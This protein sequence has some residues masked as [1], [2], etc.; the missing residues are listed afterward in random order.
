MTESLKA[1]PSF[2][3]FQSDILFSIQLPYIFIKC[4]SKPTPQ[5]TSSFHQCNKNNLFSCKFII[6]FAS[7][8]LRITKD[9]KNQTRQESTTKNNIATEMFIVYVIYAKFIG[10]IKSLSAEEKC[11][12]TVLFVQ[13]YVCKSYTVAQLAGITAETV[14]TLADV[15]AKDVDVAVGDH[16]TAVVYNDHLSFRPKTA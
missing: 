11:S 6:L 1:P 4:I 9:N 7:R 5:N 2:L 15:Q 16:R 12:C 14:A 13:N 10:L 8:A 3:L